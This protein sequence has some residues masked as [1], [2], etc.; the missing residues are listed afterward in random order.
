[1]RNVIRFKHKVAS[2]RTYE[3]AQF[4]RGTD[5]IE[6]HFAQGDGDRH[7]AKVHYDD[8]RMEIFYECTQVEFDKERTV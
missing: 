2:G 7:Y 3:K 6:Y 5:R 1:M 8:G 4:D